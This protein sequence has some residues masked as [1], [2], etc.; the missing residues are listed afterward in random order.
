VPVAGVDIYVTNKAVDGKTLVELAKEPTARGSSCGRSRGAQRPR[1]FHPAEHPDPARR[2][3]HPCRP[4][5]GHQCLHQ[6]AGRPGSPDR[7]CRCCVYWRRDRDW[8]AGGLAGLQGEGGAPDAF[9]AAARSSRGSCLGG[10]ARSAR[11]SGI[12]RPHHLVH[13]LGRPQHLH[14]H[15]RYL[16]G[17]G[18]VDGLKRRVSVFSCGGPSRPRSP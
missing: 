16:R 1:I 15:R 5:A 13:E 18:F 9:T 4:H 10:C 17:P 11:S 2:H 7:R 8:R 14:C 6:A 3:P 12:F